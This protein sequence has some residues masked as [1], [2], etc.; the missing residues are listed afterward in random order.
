M[1]RRPTWRDPSPVVPLVR[2]SAFDIAAVGIDPQSVGE[3]IIVR[4]WSR[5][6]G[7][8]VGSANHSGFVGGRRC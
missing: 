8:P 1:L 2:E 7:G 6:L 3:I 5:L 4:V